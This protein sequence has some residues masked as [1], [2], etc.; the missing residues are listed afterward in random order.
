[1]Y[2]VH[3]RV[4]RFF[5]TYQ[6]VKKYT[7]LPQNTYIPITKSHKIYIVA[8]KI[9]NGHKIYQID[10]KYTNISHSKVLQIGIFG[11]QSY[12]V[13]RTFFC[14]DLPIGRHVWQPWYIHCL[15]M[16]VFSMNIF[17]RHTQAPTFSRKISKA[18]SD[19]LQKPSRH[20][21]IFSGIMLIRRNRGAI[22]S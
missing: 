2:I 5:T 19:C 16:K 15:S 10:I 1:M 11:T 7:K 13:G 22:F 20:S 17:P 9:P 18:K 6:N 4:A 21:W 12:R 14:T 8:V 3:I